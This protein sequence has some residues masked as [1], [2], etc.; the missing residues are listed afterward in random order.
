MER[1]SYLN[2]A[3]FAF[4]YEA[5]ELFTYS[6][7]QAPAC[8]I[9]QP[10]FSPF[11][12]LSYLSNH[13]FLSLHFVLSF[14]P[15]FPHFSLCISKVTPKWLD[16]LQ[17]TNYKSVS[18]VR[19][20]TMRQTLSHGGLIRVKY[21]QAWHFMLRGIATFQIY[22][23]RSHRLWN[24][25][26]RNPAL[27]ARVLA[28]HKIPPHTYFAIIFREKDIGLKKPHFLTRAQH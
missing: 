22:N 20:L 14:N 18:K 24:G 9:F 28:A 17:E 21:L 11:F 27:L 16:G 2:C 5:M 10:T 26:L 7:P 12:A 6:L 23:Q 8:L 15:H 13:I 3:W 1:C 4:P 19:H 25:T